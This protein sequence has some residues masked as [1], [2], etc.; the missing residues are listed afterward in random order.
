VQSKLEAKVGEI[1]ELV[2][3]LGTIKDR[4]PREAPSPLE[5]KAIRPSAERPWSSSI[6]TVNMNGAFG[7]LMPAI[8]EDKQHPETS[9][10]YVSLLF[11]VKDT[12]RSKP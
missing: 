10:G 5:I 11:S 9:L 6:G 2:K 7:G 4:M 12:N 3:G 1:N 8:T